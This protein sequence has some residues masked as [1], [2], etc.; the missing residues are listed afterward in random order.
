MDRAIA[1]QLEELKEAYTA[2]IAQRKSDIK[3]A[4]AKGMVVSDI[5]FGFFLWFFSLVVFVDCNFIIYLSF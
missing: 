1:K 5:F 3:A 2:K 4:G